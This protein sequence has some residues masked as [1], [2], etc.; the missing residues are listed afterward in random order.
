MITRQMYEAIEGLRSWLRRIEPLEDLPRTLISYQA[1]RKGLG[2]LAEAGMPQCCHHTRRLPRGEERQQGANSA[3]STP[4]A[5][6]KRHPDWS[7][8]RCE[9]QPGGVNSCVVFVD[10]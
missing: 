7:L 2:R 4:K 5:M 6:Y 8:K 1:L 9:Q 10:R 3:E